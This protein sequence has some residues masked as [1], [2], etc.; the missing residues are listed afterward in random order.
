MKSEPAIEKK[1]RC[2]AAESHNVSDDSCEFKL[3]SSWDILCCLIGQMTRS[4]STAAFVFEPTV[5]MLKKE[6]FY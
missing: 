1:H 2:S 6:G 5:A 4:K 3:C